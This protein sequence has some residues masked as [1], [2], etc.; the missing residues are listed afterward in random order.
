[1]NTPLV[2]QLD[3]TRLQMN[4]AYTAPYGDCLRLARKLERERNA[5]SDQVN[6]LERLLLMVADWDALG[7]GDKEAL[8]ALHRKHFPDNYT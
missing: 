4:M 8:F 3:R 5:L 2:D 6:D 1:M 7:E